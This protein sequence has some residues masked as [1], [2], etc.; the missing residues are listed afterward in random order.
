[1]NNFK[2]MV[3]ILRTCNFFDFPRD[4]KTAEDHLFM[5]PTS[6]LN[7]IDISCIFLYI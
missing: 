2:Q 7:Q 5:V 6:L 1:M 3:W 4:L